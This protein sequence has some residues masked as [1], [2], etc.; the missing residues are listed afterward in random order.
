MILK[1][2]LYP[3]PRQAALVAR[4]HLHHVLHTGLRRKLTLLSA[5][6]GFG[7]TTLA[8]NWLREQ[9]FPFAWLSL[10]D[11][12][13]DPSRFW[14][15]VVAALQTVTP[16]LGVGVQ[17][18]LEAPQS[19]PLE[20]LVGALINEIM[21]QAETPLVF[22]LDDYH[23]IREEA[24]H[25]SVNYLLDHQPPSFH[26]IVLTRSDPPLKLARRLGRR[27]M[28][29]LRTADLRLSRPEATTF[30]NEVMALDLSEAD[31]ETLTKRT[32]GW[33]TGLHLVALSLDQQENRAAFVRD[34][35]GNDR[36]VMDYLVDEVFSKQPAETQ[37]FLLYTSV[38]DRLCPVLCQELFEGLST[39]ASVA[40]APVDATAMLR[41]VEASNLFLQPLDTER[42]WYQYHP[43]FAEMLRQ[44][45]HRQEPDVVSDL[46]LR[47]SLW[48]E[49]ADLMQDAIRHALA[50]RHEQRAIQLIT[51]EATAL[52]N[53]GRFITLR[54][55]LEAISKDV[56]LSHPDLVLLYA[57]VLAFSGHTPREYTAL[58]EQVEARLEGEADTRRRG[59][60]ALIRTAAAID[61]G[62]AD[63]AVRYGRRALALL[64][65]T[66][67]SRGWTL[68][69]LGMA[70]VQVG[71]LVEAAPLLRTAFRENEEVGNRFL[72]L[73][74][75]VWLG[76]LYL[77]QGALKQ[78]EE[79]IEQIKQTA[80]EDLWQRL[81]GLHVLEARWCYER[82]ELEAAANALARAQQAVEQTGRRFWNLDL[83]ADRAHL[84]WLQG[85]WEAATAYLDTALEQAR[86]L[87][88]QYARLR[89]HAMKA[90]WD[91]QR[92]QRAAAL[93]TCEMEML[94][95]GNLVTFETE[96]LYRLLVQIR[97][98]EERYDEALYLLNRIIEVAEK[99]GR[100]YH[101]TQLLARKACVEHLQG[102]PDAV[103]TLSE[104]LNRAE[105]EAYLRTFLD[106]GAPMI[107]LLRTAL[108]QSEAPSAYLHT[109]LVTCEQEYEASATPAS[110]T[111]HALSTAEILSER[112][113]DVL[114]LLAEDL[115]NADIA[116]RLF[117]SLN[118]VKTHTKNIYSK[119]YVHDR[120]EAVKQAQKLGLL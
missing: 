87:Q 108:L 102:S 18:M 26:L 10:N 51:M 77:D 109:L 57:R 65:K 25:R 48:F 12:D 64:S 94:R 107:A 113:L 83:Y 115:P 105:R 98:D 17:E 63:E 38:L 89:T 112:E 47:A 74:T 23:E 33:V 120:R 50:G 3:P 82:N 101:A 30:L 13:N 24:I 55:W 86:L 46:H 72:A 95:I 56:L 119:L 15:Y 79:T 99:D 111:H 97:I 9:G 93:R 73:S 35:A 27:E 81:A 32:E 70:Y 53:S 42:W 61:H 88:N 29:E 28:V 116:D 80:A 91:L 96:P 52:L 103:G 84:A 76:H 49:K 1:T 85:D 40:D 19:P 62:R 75:V 22:V 37:R 20:A 14:T 60:I 41:T 69:S 100:H 44:R 66:D 45:V 78:V 36:Y 39:D 68:L 43:L 8:C 6:A 31:V 117:V 58:L 118:T 2:K 114:R 92:G 21:S 110:P 7:K 11:E 106:A 54:R 104:V 59:E 34:F 4:G 5:P 71:N 16:E 67:R 90:G